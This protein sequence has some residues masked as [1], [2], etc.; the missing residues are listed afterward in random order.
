MSNKSEEMGINGN[1]LVVNFEFTPPGQL[2][3]FFSFSPQTPTTLMVDNK[4]GENLDVVV[5]VVVVEIRQSVF[6]FRRGET[7]LQS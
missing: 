1:V 3:T 5:V 7:S 2:T 4:Q 6:S